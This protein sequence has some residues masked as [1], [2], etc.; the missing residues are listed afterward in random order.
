VIFEDEA[1]FWVDGTLHQT[2][3]RVGVQPRVNTYGQRKTAHLFGAIA[4]EDATFTYKFAAKFKGHTFLAFIKQIVAKYA[5]RKVF[6]IIDNAPHH[7]LCAAGK[8]WLHA[9]RKRIELHRLPPYSPEFMPMEGVWKTT[10]KYATHNSFHETP[11]K[12]DA[13]LRRTFK[14]FQRRSSIIAAHVR[15]FA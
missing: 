10:R 2:W 1:S 3:S 6:M 12:R 7:N 8:S 4:L 13:A 15:R 11:Q 9:N 14:R 5:P